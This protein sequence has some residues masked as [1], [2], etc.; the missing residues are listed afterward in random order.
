MLFRSLGIGSS[1]DSGAPRAISSRIYER[2]CP[3]DERVYIDRETVKEHMTSLGYHAGIVDE[4]DGTEVM[5]AWLK[6]LRTEKYRNARCI[7]VRRDT[8]HVFDMWSVH[9]LRSS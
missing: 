5:N 8:Y 3:L 1:S 7:E 2:V 4:G 9:F 6:V